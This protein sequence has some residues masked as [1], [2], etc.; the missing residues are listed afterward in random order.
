MRY[1]GARE[2]EI[3]RALGRAH[4][5]IHLKGGI[6]LSIDPL[7]PPA[8]SVGGNR[9]DSAGMIPDSGWRSGS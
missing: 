7:R 1:F 8:L 9:K 6:A 3:V 2:R 5:V 4:N